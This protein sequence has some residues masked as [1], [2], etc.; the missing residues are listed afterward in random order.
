MPERS[1]EENRRELD[2][3]CAHALG[4]ITFWGDGGFGE[5][6]Y[7][8]DKEAIRD[9]N[10]AR[11]CHLL[12]A[13][14]ERVRVDGE[15]HELMVRLCP[16]FSARLEDAKILEDEIARRGIEEG[17]AA[18]LAA[19]C[20]I[21]GLRNFNPVAYTRRDLWEIAHATPEQRARA[22]VKVVERP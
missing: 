10:G 9:G 7:L 22:F 17:Y 18:A 19:M 20:G 13:R 3:R 6:L 4:Y 2:E 16:A 11:N 8:W 15:I 21:T 12:G 14:W 5:T 1:P